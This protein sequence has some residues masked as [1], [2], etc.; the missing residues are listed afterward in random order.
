M[1]SGDLKRAKI[2][3]CTMY[4]RLVR[5]RMMT[6]QCCPTTSTR[7]STSLFRED[8]KSDS[9]PRFESIKAQPARRSESNE[10]PSESGPGTEV[11]R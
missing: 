1:A 9:T 5:A 10:E 2:R 7:S 6:S 11:D 4:W 8:D 3:S